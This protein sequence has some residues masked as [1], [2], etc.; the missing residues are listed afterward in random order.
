MSGPTQA[1]H[2]KNVFL[3]LLAVLIKRLQNFAG[4][5]RTGFINIKYSLQA[6]TQQQPKYLKGHQVP[7]NFRTTA[8]L[9][10]I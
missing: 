4:V 8:W 5:S 6:C 2:A 9:K 10:N 3:V 1:C 7:V